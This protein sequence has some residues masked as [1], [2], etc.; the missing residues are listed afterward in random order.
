MH[1]G[2]PGAIRAVAFDLGGVLVDVDRRRAC[3]K[4]GVDRLAFDAAFFHGGAHDDVTVGVLSGEA[5]LARAGERLARSAHDIRAASQALVAVMPESAALV[6]A[7]RVP[8]LIWSNTDPVHWEAMEPAL[9]ASMRVDVARHALSFVVGAQKPE[10][11]YYERALARA[12]LIAGDV[13]FLDDRV[14][15]VEGA[16]ALGIAAEPTLGIEA[17]RR[18]L[19]LY[20][21]L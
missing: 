5:F 9:P 21:L 4:L 1:K 11:A 14:E 19:A 6:E 2:A 7:V 15:N 12:G 16:R 20:G 10:A 3:A 17:A 18:H 8:A 13:L